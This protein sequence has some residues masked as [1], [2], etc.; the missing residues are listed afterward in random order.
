[1]G[2]IMVIYC[3][4]SPT[5]DGRLGKDHLI[6]CAIIEPGFYFRKRRG[7]MLQK[8]RNRRC[9]TSETMCVQKKGKSTKV[10]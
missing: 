8:P 7:W 9:M 1:M 10:N 4:H 3:M 6:G 2:L 5:D